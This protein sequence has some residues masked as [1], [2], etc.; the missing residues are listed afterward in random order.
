VR[1]QR[2]AL[3]R[4]RAADVHVPAAP[5]TDLIHPGVLR[6]IPE[7]GIVRSRFRERRALPI[8]RASR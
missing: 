2:A 5:R 6:Y 7:V 4:Q 8:N 3:G 1:L